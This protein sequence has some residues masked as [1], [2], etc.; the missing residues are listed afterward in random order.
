[1]IQRMLLAA[2]V[3]ATLAF[4]AGRAP[5]QGLDAKNVTVSNVSINPTTVQSLGGPVAVSFRLKKK[6]N[7]AIRAVSVFVKQNGKNGPAV[8]ATEQAGNGYTATPT[9]GG[10]ST[11]NAI[12]ATLFVKVRTNRGT[13][14]VKLGTVRVEGQP[15]DPTQPPPPPPI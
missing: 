13:N 2:T 9:V 11:R 1:M 4:T 7:I 3:V 10:N 8:P 15:N 12:T 6:K 14:N 5:A